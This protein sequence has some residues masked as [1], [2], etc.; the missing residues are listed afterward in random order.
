MVV[1]V[2]CPMFGFGVCLMLLVVFVVWLYYQHMSPMTVRTIVTGIYCNMPM[3]TYFRNLGPFG[4]GFNLPKVV[5]SSVYL[6]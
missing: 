4:Q 2:W 5:P 1:G 3:S 6:L